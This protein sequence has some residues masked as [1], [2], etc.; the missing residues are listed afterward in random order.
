MQIAP[1]DTF[2]RINKR[3]QQISSVFGWIYYHPG[4]FLVEIA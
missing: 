3:L 4:I 2:L 1:N